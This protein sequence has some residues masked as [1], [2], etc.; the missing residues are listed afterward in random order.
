MAGTAR[1]HAAGFGVS[2]VTHPEGRSTG[3]LWTGPETPRPF[4]PPQGLSG[5]FL[6]DCL[7]GRG[8]G[9]LLFQPPDT[10]D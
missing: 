9:A 8:G 10:S 1:V 7:Q 6:G 5:A 4:L 3:G 2:Q